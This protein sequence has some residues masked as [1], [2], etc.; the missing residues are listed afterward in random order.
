MSINLVIEDGSGA[1]G[2][3]TYV[4]LTEA[5]DIA[6]QFGWVLSDDDT[7]AKQDL[8]NGYQYLNSLEGGMSGDRAYEDQT[9]AF[10]REGCKCGPFVVPSNV[11][12][13]EVKQAQVR[14][15]VS[16]S[17]GVDVNPDDKGKSIASESVAGAVSVSYFNNG[18]TGG[19]VKITEA[20]QFLERCYLT[21]AIG[22][23]FN[24]GRA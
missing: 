22:I 7:K 12:K 20:I 5:R 15:G 18:K 9:G 3:N 6:S 4:D 23:S 14:A 1:L 24:T 8:I 17:A 2:A 21:K 10:P 13:P 16:F 11:I 19:S